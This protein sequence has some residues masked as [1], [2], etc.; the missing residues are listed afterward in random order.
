M[1]S[2]IHPAASAD[3]INYTY[4]K[5]FFGCASQT[6]TINGQVMTVAGPA[7]IDM[8]VTSISLGTANCIFLIGNDCC[9]ASTGAVGKGYFY[10]GQ[11]N[12]YDSGDGDNIPTYEN[13]DGD[14]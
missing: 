8:D 12:P 2:V 14:I 3:F 7:T 5:I 1:A 13:D 4:H 11:N 6:A 10:L 9:Q